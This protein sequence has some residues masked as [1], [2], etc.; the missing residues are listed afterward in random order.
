MCSF[1]IFHDTFWWVYGDS[2]SSFPCLL[3]PSYCLLFQ[4][5]EFKIPRGFLRRTPNTWCLSLY[6]HYSYSTLLIFQVQGWKRKKQRRE[7]NFFISWKGDQ[8]FF[9]F[10]IPPKSPSLFDHLSCIPGSWWYLPL[11][12][13]A[14]SHGNGTVMKASGRGSRMWGYVTDVRQW[15]GDNWNISAATRI[16]DSPSHLWGLT[17]T[18]TSCF[19]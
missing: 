14:G 18:F 11:W 16:A 7:G 2:F 17:V 4:C 3:F 12:F 1:I 5:L 13:Q 10:S 6:F 9:S 8:L 15:Q 19:L